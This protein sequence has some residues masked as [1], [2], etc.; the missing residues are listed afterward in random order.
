MDG[1]GR[2]AARAHPL[3]PMALSEI[4]DEKTLAAALAA[5]LVLLFKHSPICP[6]SARA[7]AELHAFLAAHPDTPSAWVDVLAQRPL[8][9]TVA[10]ATGVEH[11]SPQAIVLAGG[12]V[13]WHASH[14]A[15]TE[16]TLA[17]AWGAAG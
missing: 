11:E 2:A 14:G 9:Q 16:E 5:D 3:S 6:I 4:T 10:A 15:I 12:K 7:L 13:V 1:D 17:R 8:S